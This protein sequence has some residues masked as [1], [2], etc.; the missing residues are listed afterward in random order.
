[1]EAWSVMKAKEA[2]LYLAQRGP[3]TEINQLKAKTAIH[4]ILQVG[5]KESLVNDQNFQKLKK[6]GDATAIN[7][8]EA[9]KM[10]D[11]WTNFESIMNG[12]I[13]D[14]GGATSPHPTRGRPSRFQ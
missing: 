13:G 6:T 9:Q 8:Y 14:S 10:T 3:Q 1:M 2:A 12:G 7:E 11:A 5:V 4:K